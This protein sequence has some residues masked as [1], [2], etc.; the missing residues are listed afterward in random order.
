MKIYDM[1]NIVI[2]ILLVISFVRTEF[3]IIYTGM[4][5]EKI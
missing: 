5:I 2:I 3:T 4:N 1:K